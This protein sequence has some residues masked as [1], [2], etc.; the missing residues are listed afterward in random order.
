M[1]SQFAI[2]SHAFGMM[3]HPHPTLS[4]AFMEAVENAS[5]EGVHG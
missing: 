2:D 5:G 1:M 4:E 3:I